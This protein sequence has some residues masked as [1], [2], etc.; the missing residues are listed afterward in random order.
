MLAQGS[1]EAHAPVTQISHGSGAGG[2][3]A[4]LGVGPGLGGVGPGLG[5]SSHLLWHSA[6]H[7][8]NSSASEG[9]SEM[10]DEKLPPGQA[11]GAGGVGDGG[12][13]DGGAGDGA[14][15]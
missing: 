8:L 13:G 10:H 6:M 9:Q 14:A 12:V 7:S 2:E 11:A 3:G 5:G 1:Q 15:G 4:G